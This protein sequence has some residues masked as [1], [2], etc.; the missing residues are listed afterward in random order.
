MMHAAAYAVFD[1]SDDLLPRV[2]PYRLIVDGL[3]VNPDDVRRRRQRQGILLQLFHSLL[4]EHAAR[5]QFGG[6]LELVPDRA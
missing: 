3:N 1:Y 2:R 5:E 6:S 4:K